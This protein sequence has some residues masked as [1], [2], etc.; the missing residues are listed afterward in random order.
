MSKVKIITRTVGQYFGCEASITRGKKTLWTSDTYPL[1]CRHR[2]YIAA[3]SEATR[4]G[5]RI[6][7]E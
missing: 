6:V 2:A 3:E 5:L 1:G 4:R 7:E